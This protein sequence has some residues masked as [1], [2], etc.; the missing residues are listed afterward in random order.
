MKLAQSGRDLAQSVKLGVHRWLLTSSS[1][2][3]WAEK[4]TELTLTKMTT[5]N[6]FPFRLPMP[7][8][9]KK[10]LRVTKNG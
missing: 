9:I 5:K 2:Q 7:Q 3:A 6:F 4:R 1:V 8:G 10:Q